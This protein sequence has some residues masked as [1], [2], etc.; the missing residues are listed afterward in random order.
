MTLL[1]GNPGAA[2]CLYEPAAGAI[3][4]SD[5][6]RSVPCTPR[7][8]LAADHMFEW[9]LVTY[10]PTNDAYTVAAHLWIGRHDGSDTFFQIGS[11]EHPRETLILKGNLVLYPEV[12]K[13]QNREEESG[14]N[15]LTIGQADNPAV[16]ASLKIHNEPGQG[17]TVLSGMQYQGDDR[18]SPVSVYGGELHVYN[19]TLTAAIQDKPHAIGAGGGRHLFLPGYGGRVVLRHAT[20]SWVAGV[21]AFGMNAHCS[22]VVDSVF[23]NSGGALINPEQAATNCVFR[24]LGTAIQDWGGPLDALLTDCTFENNDANWSLS[25]GRLR[26]VDCVFGLPRQGNRY[27]SWPSQRE[28][29]APYACFR[30]SRHVIVEVK[31]MTGKPVKGARVEMTTPQDTLARQCAATDEL[32][33]TPGRRLDTALLLTEREETATDVPDQPRVTEYEY[34]LSVTAPSHDPVTVRGMRPRESWQIIPIVLP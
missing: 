28:G 13:G 32:G 5:Y 14:V 25:R 15:R 34:T 9:G 16:R 18:P 31:D 4:V 1:G 11:R 20:L 19:G 6:P 29:K 17:H 30:S 10:D 21:I 3:W 8:L 27:K 33:R 23:E 2:L 7:Q 24:N 22:E 12:V 26:C